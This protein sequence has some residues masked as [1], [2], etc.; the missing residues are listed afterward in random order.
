MN[1]PQPPTMDPLRQYYLGRMEERIRQLE[2]A[3]LAWLKGSGDEAIRRIAHQMKGTGTSFGFPDVS[4]A[5]A[6]L[7]TAGDDFGSRLEALLEILRNH[8]S[9]PSADSAP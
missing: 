6:V 9:P 2:T 1:G 7:E 4:A 8:L 3:R 5:A